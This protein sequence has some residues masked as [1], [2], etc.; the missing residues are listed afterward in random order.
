[1]PGHAD[2]T[3]SGAQ[4]FSPDGVA[5]DGE[6]NIYVAD[7]INNRIRKVSSAG[8]VTTLAGGTAG[9]ADG[10]GAAAQFSAS[11]LLRLM[12]QET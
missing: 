3:A 5:V 9:Y 12:A 1:M 7:E 8:V 11:Q 6:G 10:T 2:G 4:F